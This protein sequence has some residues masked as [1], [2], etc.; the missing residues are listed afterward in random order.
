[1]DMATRKKTKS[2]RTINLKR[3]LMCVGL[4]VFALYFSI[5]FLEQQR[6][7]NHNSMQIA[8]VQAQ[9]EEALLRNAV[10][11]ETLAQVETDEHIQRAARK[12]G[13]AM[14]GD[15]IYVDAARNR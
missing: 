3:L 1:M 4:I 15:R 9:T 6:Q 13:F 2:I 12:R 14:P 10:L 5:A 8:E 11:Q 7:I